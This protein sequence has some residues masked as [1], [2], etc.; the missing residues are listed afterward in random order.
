MECQAIAYK[1]GGVLQ[2]QI[3]DE[4]KQIQDK[5]ERKTVQNRLAQ[6]TRST[7]QGIYKATLEF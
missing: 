3:V 7:G 1:G 6:R 4:W 5:S 2:V